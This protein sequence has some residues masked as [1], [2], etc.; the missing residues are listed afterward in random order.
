M[1]ALITIVVLSALMVS[2][3]FRIQLE[4]DL[5]VRERFGLKAESLS[6]AG[7]EYAKWML[8]KSG[9]AG[10]EA[11]DDME[12]RFFV[13]T[14]NLQ[15]GVA[16]Q[17][18][19]VEM[20]DGDILISISPETSRRNVNRLSDPDWEQMLSNSG[21]PDA[22]HAKLIAA[23]RDWVDEDEATR[24]LGAEE[25]DR[26]YR[27][28]GL[29]VKNGPVESLAELGMIRGFTRAVLYGGALSEYY[30]KPDIQF[31]GIAGLLSVFGDQSVNLNSASRE[32]LLSLSGIREEQVD[33]LI[34]GRAGTDGEF[35]TEDDG[36]QTVQQGLAAGSLPGDIENIFNT[37][38]L[39][40]VRVVSIGQVGD[41][42]KGS[43]AIY[44][45]TGNDLILLSYEA[46]D[47]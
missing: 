16:L 35:G 42:K 38:D 41:I 29:P 2:F 15:R 1:L 24:L 12:E 39:R 34:E 6:R 3:L 32:V 25:D 28:L 10:N 37:R 43:L 46:R 19:R 40:W 30:D 5:A 14:K 18:Y 33:N 9:R 11:E 13:A 22:Y 4:T 8:I 44:E 27:D 26:Y 45:F 23:F 31:T 20:E 17:S 21:M 36:Y 47:L 7:L